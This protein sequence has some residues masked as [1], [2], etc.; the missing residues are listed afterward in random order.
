MDLV[1]VVGDVVRMFEAARPQDVALE[2]DAAP[3]LTV[4]AD[5]TQVRQILWNLILKSVQAM[6]AGGRIRISLCEVAEDPQES[7]SEDRNEA[8]GGAGFVEVTVTDTGVGI[9][10][11]VLD[12]IFDPF[13]TTKRD[14]TGLG[15]ATV[16]RI[17]EAN[18]GN[19]RVESRVSEGTVF[20]VRLPRPGDDS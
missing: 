1:A 10:P 13:F 9:A 2:V 6:P 5:P 16:H 14:G 7:T 3:P 18:G 19:L 12:R 20:R 15:L 8:L 4:L 11:D 17:V